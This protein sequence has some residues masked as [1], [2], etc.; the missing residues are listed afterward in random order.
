MDRSPIRKLL[1]K[2][3]LQR[4]DLFITMENVVAK[5]MPDHHHPLVAIRREEAHRKL[6]PNGDGIPLLVAGKIS[7][8]A[9]A[10]VEQAHAPTIQGA[11]E[12]LEVKLEAL[13]RAP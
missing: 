12:T 2:H 13:G 3:R 5:A 7:Q 11:I 8:E 6:D 10:P 1:T 4:I 9:M